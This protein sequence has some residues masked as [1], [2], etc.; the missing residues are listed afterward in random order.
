M[1]VGKE[2]CSGAR[3]KSGR[4]RAGGALIGLGGF[5]AL[6]GTALAGS[7]LMAAA[8]QFIAEME[9]PPGELARQKWSQAKAA[10]AAGATAWRNGQSA[11]HADSDV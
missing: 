3:M 11:Q 7:A 2:S 9:V 5:F 10:T 6:A 1:T 4:L 8:R